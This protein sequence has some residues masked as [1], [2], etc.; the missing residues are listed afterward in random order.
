VKFETMED[1]LAADAEARRVAREEVE[2]LK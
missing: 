2:K 1:V